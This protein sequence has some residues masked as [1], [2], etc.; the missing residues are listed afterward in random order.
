MT[1]TIKKAIDNG[2]FDCGVFIDFQKAF[3]TVN[4]SIFIEKFQHYDIGGMDLDWFR[5]YLSNRKQYVPYL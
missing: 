5:S 1:E 4:H 3:D 2:I